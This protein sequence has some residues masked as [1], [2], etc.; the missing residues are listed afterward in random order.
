M[1]NRRKLKPKTRTYQVPISP[2]S[3]NTAAA[4]FAATKSCAAC[5][6]PARTVRN[7]TLHVQHAADCPALDDP[8]LIYPAT[9]QPNDTG[10]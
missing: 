9:N 5:G 4:G 10:N 6:G 8:E 3:Y 1:S 2:D 7:G